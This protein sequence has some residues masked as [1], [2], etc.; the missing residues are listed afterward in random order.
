MCMRC[1]VDSWLGVNFKDM[2]VGVSGVVRLVIGGRV[3]GGMGES[4]CWICI[5]G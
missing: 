3:G 5:A 2:W 4:V 1:I